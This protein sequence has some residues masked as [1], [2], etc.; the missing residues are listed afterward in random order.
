MRRCRRQFPSVIDITTHIYPNSSAT[1]GG[2][3]TT[4]RV[5]VGAQF[6]D[7]AKGKITDFLASDAQYVVRTGGGP[8]AGHTI[9]VGDEKVV[10]H[11]LAC[12]VLRR[13][14]TGVC[15]PGMVVNPAQLESEIQALDDRHLLHG[16][17][18]IS[19]RAHVLLT[20]HQLE[21]AWEE[22]TRSNQSGGAGLGTTQRGIG[23]A[24]RDRY[25]RWGL[26]FA[27]LVRPD[28]LEQRL[29][30]LY[31]SKPYLSNLPSREELQ[32]QLSEIG[33]RLAPQ[34]RATEPILW[35]AIERG[36]N[37]ILEGAQSAL[38]DVDYGTYPY[39]TSSHPTSA[40]ALV[41]SGIPP[42]ELDEV[43]GV[44]KAYATRVGVGPFPTEV[45]GEMGEYLRRVGGE[46][47]ATTGRPRRCGWL[48]LV[49]LKYASRLNGFTSFA[50]TK[51]DVL[52]GLDEVPVAVGYRLSDGSEVEA[53][54]PAIAEELAKA[55]PVY[56][57]FAGWPDF[58][59]R[60]R[61]RI[62]RE[63]AHALPD[64]LRRFLEF[65]AVQTRVPVEW[66]SYGPRRD[67]T[68]WMGRGART[69]TAASLSPW[70][71]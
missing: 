53:Y 10:L 16:S 51:V 49:L 4:V 32:R 60:L 25:G 47:G 58:N 30:L 48:D 46:Q 43:I 68:V 23:P 1:H 71:S 19:E 55:T 7:E 31:A 44:T 11:Q 20:L 64:P 22:Q 5:I 35:G 33:G 57:R 17:I 15:G 65:L 56:R 26:R 2:R 39:V 13:G 54:P 67:E 40:G 24:Y 36:E 28:L 42:Q 38:L 29:E 52:G 12:G 50:V 59:E 41:G 69:P 34:V 21:D 66:V 37:I 8:N 45:G 3:A 27:E 63:G 62:R 70:S 14:V 61:E 6:G 18:V 9:H